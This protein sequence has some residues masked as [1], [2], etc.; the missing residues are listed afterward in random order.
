MDNVFIERL[1]CSVKYDEVYLNDYQS[2][3]Q[4]YQGL[5]QT[6]TSTTMNARTAP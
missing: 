6:C 5:G 2:V 3:L 4:L 1:W